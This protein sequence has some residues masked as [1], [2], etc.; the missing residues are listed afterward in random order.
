MVFRKI[1]PK[2]LSQQVGWGK[3][4]S[5]AHHETVPREVLISSVTTEVCFDKDFE[6]GSLFAPGMFCA[7]G[8]GFG[9]C[10]G[11]SGS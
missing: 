8:D 2:I 11:D 7:G 1:P 3:S 5:A 4:E 6:I 10:H 9:P